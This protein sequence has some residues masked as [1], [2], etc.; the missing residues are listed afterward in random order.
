LCIESA[1][2]GTRLEIDDDAMLVRTS[3]IAGD[4]A[5]DI[6][7]A[8]RACE[9]DASPFEQYAAIERSHDAPS[10]RATCGLQG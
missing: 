2:M 3:A 6:V 9:P 1:L 8:Y 5:A 7:A 4:R 10:G